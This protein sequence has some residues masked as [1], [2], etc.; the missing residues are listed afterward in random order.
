MKHINS[1]KIFEG[2]RGK[3][4][5]GKRPKRKEVQSLSPEVKRRAILL[6]K[7]IKQILNKIK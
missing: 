1:F 7:E 5:K 3:R 6:I 4:K 2:K